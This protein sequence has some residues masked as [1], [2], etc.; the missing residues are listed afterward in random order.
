MGY[1]VGTVHIYTVYIDRSEGGRTDHFH[2]G[3]I[4]KPAPPPWLDGRGVWKKEEDERLVG[5]VVLLGVIQVSV[6][7]C[8]DRWEAYVGMK[9]AFRVADWQ[10]HRPPVIVKFSQGCQRGCRGWSG[11]ITLV[12]H[13]AA[14][15]SCGGKSRLEWGETLGWTITLCKPTGQLCLTFNWLIS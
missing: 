7:N 11:F 15:A 9:S 13:I 4:S 10:F 14:S 6:R 1:W 5:V 8:R 2:E 12:G 3:D